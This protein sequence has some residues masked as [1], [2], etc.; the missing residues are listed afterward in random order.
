MEQDVLKI[1]LK[2]YGFS[3]ILCRNAKMILPF[4]ADESGFL[5]IYKLFDGNKSFNKK[6]VN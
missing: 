2:D 6:F 4:A 3:R 1:Y 5:E